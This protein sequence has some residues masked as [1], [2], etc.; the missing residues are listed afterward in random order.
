VTDS[1]HIGLEIASNSSEVTSS[2]DTERRGFYRWPLAVFAQQHAA[3]FVDYQ[4]AALAECQMLIEDVHPLLREWT[5]QGQPTAA[6][7]DRRTLRST[8]ESSARAGYSPVNCRKGS[9]VDIAV[10]R[11]AACWR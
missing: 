2:P 9:K 5:A 8:L 10:E 11:S 7:I 1:S 3:L 4:D 6:V